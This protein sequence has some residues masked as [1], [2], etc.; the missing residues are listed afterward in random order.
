VTEI[1]TVFF[2]VGGTL[3]HPRPSFNG[4]L[5]EICQREG[6]DVSVEQAAR[7]EP[8]VWARIGPSGRGFSLSPDDSH[9][10]WLKVYQLFLDE[11]GFSAATHMP[12]RLFEDFKRPANYQ[13][14]DD[15]LPCLTQLREERLNIGIISNWEAWAPELL[16]ELGLADLVDYTIVSG[17]VGYEKPDPEIFHLALAAADVLPGHAMHVGDN[18]LDDVEGAYRVGI[19]GI[20]IDRDQAPRA[21]E[22]DQSTLYARIHERRAPIIPPG[23]RPTQSSLP[24]EHI[25]SVT[26]SSLL[27]IPRLLGSV[28]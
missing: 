9:A 8:A 16:R 19:C 18:P 14:Y 6:L 17:T 15:A 2:D 26:V 3:A 24:P 1:K 28:S 5:S 22:G 7:A 4:L 21:D 27:E 12:Q 25:R 10:F 20:L 11:L 13:L 23:P